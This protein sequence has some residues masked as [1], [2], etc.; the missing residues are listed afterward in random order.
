MVDLPTEDI[1]ENENFEYLYVLHGS[2]R[3]RVSWSMSGK[4][5]MVHMTA[6]HSRLVVASGVAL[7]GLSTG[8]NGISQSKK[9][10]VLIV[11]HGSFA[12]SSVD[13]FQWNT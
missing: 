12:A 3:N 5:K 13:S 6:L 2:G 1:L 9:G 10:R 8:Y 7:R 11:I 4:P